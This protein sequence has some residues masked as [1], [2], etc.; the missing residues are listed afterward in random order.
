MRVSV[1][2]P[3][4]N[5]EETLER[6]L[7]AIFTAF[8][9]EKDFEVIV[10]NDGSTDRTGEI[11][12]QFPVRLLHSDNNEGR[13]RAREKGA[14]AA[15]EDTLLFVDSSVLIPPDTLQTL[16]S[17]QYEPVMG[18]SATINVQDGTALDRL[19]YL[20]RKRIYAPYYPQSAAYPLIHMTVENFNRVPKG[21]GCF[22]V[23][24]SRFLS[25]MPK[26]LGRYVS[27]DTRILASLVKIKPILVPRALTTVYL[28]RQSLRDALHH[29]FQRGPLFADYHLRPGGRYYRVWIVSCLTG[30]AI[31]I[32]CV[33]NSS[34]IIPFIIFAFLILILISAR[35]SERLTDFFRI[36]T[37]LPWVALAFGFGIFRGKFYQGKRIL[38]RLRNQRG[39]AGFL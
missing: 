5:A 12:K 16:G 18:G 32:G 21:L 6:C 23:D 34:L 9:S 19:L 24:K 29:L 28:Q 36:L 33:L 35:L 31:V 10:V 14:Q 7:S 3:A 8:K 38:E 27:D 22:F 11:A 15:E 2:V 13:I 39:V 20:I 4:F 17:L 1:I 26:D 30:L 25:V 37:V